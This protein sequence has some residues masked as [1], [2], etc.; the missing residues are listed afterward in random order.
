MQQRKYNKTRQ[1]YKKKD[2]AGE[3]TKQT[4][5]KNEKKNHIKNWYNHPWTEFAW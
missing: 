1:N 3:F 4:F 2:W 5:R